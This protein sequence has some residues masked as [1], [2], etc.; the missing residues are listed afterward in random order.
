MEIKDKDL[1]IVSICMPVYNEQDDLDNLSLPS[2][3]K[4]DYPQEK[5]E[6]LIIDDD[7][8]DDTLKIAKKYNC[9]VFR[10]GAKDNET[11]RNIGYKKSKGEL[12]MSLCADM[13]F[14]DK[15][16]LKKMV[17]PFMDDEEIA[18]N[19][20]CFK[21]NKNQP[22][23]TRCISYDPWQRDPIYKITTVSPK[24]IISKKRDGW[25]ECYVTE[26]TIPPQGCTLYR[27]K[28]LK[29]YSDT[30]VQL[31]DNEI[32]TF[33]VLEGHNKWAFVPSTGIEHWI[34]RSLKEIWYKRSRNIRVL[35]M[36][37]DNRKFKW[38]TLKK[39]WPKA[40]LWLLYTNTFILP[41]IFSIYKAF[42]F[43]DVALLSEPILNLVSTYAIVYSTATSGE[44]FR[45]LK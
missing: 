4:Q 5:V 9:K 41:I 15:D 32:P 20:V 1:P 8:T 22:P 42:K 45:L 37:V 31:T 33:L 30:H 28:L 2:I 25:Y 7:S 26:K 23:L 11:G 36:T 12:F 6:I 16:F 44:M 29:P 38:F 24:K 14:R 19:L 18:G 40:A 13:V 43:R 34:F 10:N 39:D 27:K 17:K 3:R 35:S 21:V